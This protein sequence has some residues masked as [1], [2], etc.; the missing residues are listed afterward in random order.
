MDTETV[1]VNSDKE[2][3]TVQVSSIIDDEIVP[4]KTRGRPKGSKNKPKPVEI[5]GDSV[6]N[7]ES[8]GST[9]KN[10]EDSYVCE[11]DIENTVTLKK[12]KYTL[13]NLKKTIDKLEERIIKLESQLSA[14]NN[15]VFKSTLLDKYECLR[16]FIKDGQFVFTSNDIDLMTREQLSAL[17]EIAEKKVEEGV[18]IRVLRYRVKEL[19]CK[20]KML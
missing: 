3:S 7:E 14:D 10:V 19:L 18:P 17:H 4:K 13:E 5:F 15:A 1:T 20:H 12:E 11:E 2:I 9:N 6:F 16:I 8:V